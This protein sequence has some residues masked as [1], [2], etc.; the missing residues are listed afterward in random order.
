[1]IRNRLNIFN[2]IWPQDAATGYFNK[3]RLNL[4]QLLTK[5]EIKFSAHFQESIFWHLDLVIHGVAST[6]YLFAELKS[7]SNTNFFLCLAENACSSQRN[8]VR[9]KWCD[10]WKRFQTSVVLNDT[11]LTYNLLSYSRPLY[12][13]K[14]HSERN[15]IFYWLDLFFTK[16]TI[17]TIGLTAV[18]INWSRPVSKRKLT[19]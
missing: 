15:I 17:T 2:F 5:D 13:E 14:S 1:M 9:V 16:T 7:I 8:L 6:P 11:K 12:L 3:S 4:Q 18:T 19:A 10:I